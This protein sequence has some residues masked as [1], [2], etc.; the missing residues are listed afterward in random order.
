MC[1]SAHRSWS[2]SKGNIP[3]LPNE[4]EFGMICWRTTPS[5]SIK[6][7]GG[8]KYVSEVRGPSIGIESDSSGGNS[9][10]SSISATWRGQISRHRRCIVGGAGR[11]ADRA[12]FLRHQVALPITEVIAQL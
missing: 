5:P 7:D 1:W 4:I 12:D 11:G 3:R 10:S 9:G 6:T 8:F 2:M